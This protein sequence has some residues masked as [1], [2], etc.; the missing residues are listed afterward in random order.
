MR[1]FSP[2]DDFFTDRL[3]R[4]YGP[5]VFL[6]AAILIAGAYNSQS[7]IRCWPPS[8]FTGAWSLYAQETCSNKGQFKPIDFDRTS[9]PGR[10][11]EELDNVFNLSK[12][13]YLP[14]VLILQIFV[15]LA[16]RVFWRLVASTSGYYTERL[17]NGAQILVNQPKPV[18]TIAPLNGQIN[19]AMG[20]QQQRGYDV[21]AAYL[22]SALKTPFPMLCGICS[23]IRGYVLVATYLLTKFGY[24]LTSVIQIGILSAFFDVNLFSQ[25]LGGKLWDRIVVNKTLDTVI[26]NVTIHD[27]YEVELFP[28]SV[29]CDFQVG[30]KFFEYGHLLHFLC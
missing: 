1:L 8:H 28:R 22:V 17:V 2:S 12:M 18:A 13:R 3:C 27:E 15:F 5:L 19:G 29:Q 11:E 16:P 26:N 21:L 30:L 23:A 20:T 4:R 7:A 10:D 9:I 6:L 25:R 24:L 14:V